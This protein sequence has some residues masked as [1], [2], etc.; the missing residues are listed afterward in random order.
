MFSADEVQRIL[1]AV[2]RGWLDGQADP[3]R[4]IALE[5]ALDW[6]SKVRAQQLLLDLIM[7][8]D[9]AIGVR[10]DGEIRFTRAGKAPR[11]APTDWDALLR[12]DGRE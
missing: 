11:I 3:P 9:V 2:D 7:S 8:G 12:F 5:R 10:P 6:G 1:E 4:D